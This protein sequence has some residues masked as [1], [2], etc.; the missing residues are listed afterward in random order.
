MKPATLGDGMC[1]TTILGLSTGAR[2]YDLTLGGPSD[3]D[4]A[5]KDTLA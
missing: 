5:E 2:N 3:Q 4:A 1:N